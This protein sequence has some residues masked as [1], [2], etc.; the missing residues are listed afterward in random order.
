MDKASRESQK[1]MAE[2]KKSADAAGKAIAGIGI[3]AAA[4]LTAITVN[5]AETA[6][7]ISRMATVANAGTT[8]FQKFAAGAEA[9]GISQEK[10]SDILKDVNDRVGDFLTTGGGPMKD[11]FEQIAPKVGVTAEQFKNLSGPQALGLY[12]DSLEKA[13]VNQQ[14]MTFFMEAMASDA[15]SLIPLLRDNGKAM[16]DYGDQAEKLG[17]ILSEDT[18]KAGKAFKKE[19]DLLGRVASGVGQQVAA[20]L[21]PDLAELTKT[22]RDPKTVEAATAMAKGVATAFSTIIKGARET[23]GIIKWAAESAAAFMNGIA[24][25]DLVRL[26]DELDRLEQMKAG[27]AL[28]KLVFFGRDGIVEYYDEQELNVEI[29]K[30]K[31][32]ISKA[33]EGAPAI[34]FPEEPKTGENKPGDGKPKNNVTVPPASK[35]K[36]AADAVQKITEEQK[37]YNAALEA[38]QDLVKD[39]RTDEEQLTDQLK[40][41][42]SV[43]D[44][45]PGVS[46][47]DRRDLAA[48]AIDASFTDAPGFEG[49][50]SAVTGAAG[51]FGKLNDAQEALDEWYEAQIE[52]L[53]QYRQDRADLTAEWDA[54]ELELKQQHEEGLARIEQD[55]QL[56]ALSAA[57]STFNTLSSLTAQF[58][59][60]QSALYKTMF[61]AEKAAAIAR[62]SIAITEGIALAAANPFPLNLAAMATVAAATAG[63]VGNIAAVGMAHD[64]IDSVPQDG[65]WLL[66]KGERVTTSET[67]AKLDNTLDQV[68]KN[69]EKPQSNIQIINNGDPRHD[70]GGVANHPFRDI[71]HYKGQQ[72]NQPTYDSCANP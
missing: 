71:T 58:A 60:E 50:D 42:L 27:G 4:G 16:K 31:E 64:G 6:D 70:I 8:E 59:G 9:V 49:S 41:R 30:L 20:E 22:L 15:T 37:K 61:L 67:S 29:A 21:L 57:E 3:A 48:R 54:Q 17:L 40:E 53:N 62:A 69:M 36:E 10:L 14:E 18:I 1:R 38:Y 7:E 63:L 2:I 19:L 35:V 56:V 32:A 5:A 13:G 11:F 25:D 34:D 47:A 44:A 68:N 52:R 45:A 24:P 23:V 28:D 55:R 43:I 12:V 26:N 51:E 33:M 65:T 72:S 39:L 66:Q 46:G